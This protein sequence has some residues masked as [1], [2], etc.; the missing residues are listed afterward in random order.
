[1]N[2]VPTTA[3]DT[4]AAQHADDLHAGSRCL[5]YMK[6]SPTY[7]ADTSGDFPTVKGSRPMRRRTASPRIR[8]TASARG[9]HGLCNWPAPAADEQTAVDDLW[10]AGV[11]GRGAYFSATDPVSLGNSISATLAQVAASAVFLLRVQ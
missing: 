6:Y 5:G 7:S 10:H 2:N 4:N 1:M 11:N 9:S 8:P 3:T